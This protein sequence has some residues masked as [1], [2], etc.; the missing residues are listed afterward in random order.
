MQ[1]QGRLCISAHPIPGHSHGGVSG[2]IDD[3]AA[4]E[5]VTRTE[6]LPLPAPDD[7]MYQGL[8]IENWQQIED[9]GYRL[10]LRA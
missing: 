1:P 9:V 6:S 4:L 3:P 5:G 2:A 7:R 10:A 8:V